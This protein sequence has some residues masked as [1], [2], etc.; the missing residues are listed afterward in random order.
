MKYWIRSLQTEKFLLL[1]QKLTK[2]LLKM[3][4]NVFRAQMAL[5]PNVRAPT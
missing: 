3:R 5:S 1:K 2:R 4:L